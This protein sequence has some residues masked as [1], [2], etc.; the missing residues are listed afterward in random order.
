MARD[1]VRE[2][3]AYLRV[4]KG[5]SA[6]TLSSYGR[7][8][9]KLRLWAAGLGRQLHEI[10]EGDLK[11]WLRSLMHAGLSART[12][13][14]TLSAARGLFHFLILD[15]HLDRDPLS[16]VEAPQTAQTLPRFLNEDELELVLSAPNLQTDEGIRDRSMFELLYAT[17]LRVSEL[18][19]LRLCDIDLDRGLLECMGK[20][21]KQRHVPVG[22]SALRWL[23]EYL[24]VRRKLVGSELGKDSGLL[25]VNASGRALTRQ[26]VWAR[27]RDYAEQV[28]LDGVTP[29]GLRHSFA[30]HLLQRGADSRSVQAMLGHSDIGTTQI[31]THITGQRLRTT[32][33]AHHP[34][35]KELRSKQRQPYLEK[36]STANGEDNL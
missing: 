17:G 24:K 29:H 25:F 26:A 16:N 2:Y 32:Y 36:S 6:N 22:R 33:D 9:E 8:L 14:R 30:T 21:S 31:Y 15:G 5:L 3:L 20:G 23:T 27:L 1:F 13:A 10:G 7:D 18:V 11:A 4:E 19:N 34:R 35:A 28:G 12:I